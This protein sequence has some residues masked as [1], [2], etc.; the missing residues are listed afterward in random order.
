MPAADK[1]LPATDDLSPGFQHHLTLHA[2]VME[3][4]VI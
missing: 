4:V 1:M 3:P 2:L